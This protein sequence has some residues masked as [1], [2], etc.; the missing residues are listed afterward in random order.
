MHTYGVSVGDAGVTA[1]TS[2]FCRQRDSE[3]DS[4]TN[5]EGRETLENVKKTQAGRHTKKR[6]ER[7]TQKET[8]RESVRAMT[9]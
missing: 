1:K 8:E 3:S 9:E 2:C 6:N 7:A 5:V 4:G